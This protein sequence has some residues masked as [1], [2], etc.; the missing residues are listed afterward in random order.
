LPTG[1]FF[2]VASKGNTGGGGQEKSVDFYI[3]KNL[4]CQLNDMLLLLSHAM[5]FLRVVHGGLA[6]RFSFP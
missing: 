2:S 5:V 1:H 4:I 3:N 6:A